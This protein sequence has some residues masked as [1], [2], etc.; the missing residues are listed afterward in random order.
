MIGLVLVTHGQLATEFRHAVEH[1]VG[2]QDNF[3]TV[4]IGAD[5]DMEQRRADIVDAVAR[6][7]TGAGV[8]VLT[9]MFGGTP[10]NL[11]ISVME[12][13]RTEVIAG[14]NLPMLIKLSSIRKGDNMAAALDEAQAAGRKYI[15]VA[16]QL[17]SSK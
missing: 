6:V 14:M 12:S 10:S 2:P 1:V 15:N 17:L 16:S 8:I 4:A 5:D 13:G 9:D 11:A 7:D 3:E